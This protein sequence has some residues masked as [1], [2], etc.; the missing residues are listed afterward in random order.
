MGYIHAFTR[1]NFTLHSLFS[2][3]T[4]AA[5]IILPGGVVTITA[6]PFYIRRGYSVKLL[7]IYARITQTGAASAGE[8]RN[9]VRAIGERPELH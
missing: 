2:S 3:L 4:Q 8:Y 9:M 6:C 7:P 5:A 1:M